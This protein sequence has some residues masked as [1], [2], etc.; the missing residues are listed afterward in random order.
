MIPLSGMSNRQLG[1]LIRNAATT[2]HE[3]QNGFWKFDFGGSLVFV[4]TDESHNRMR[5]MTPIVEVD[6]ISTD[7]LHLLLSAN[8]D[9][10]LDAR[11]CVNDNALWS[12]FLHPLRELD[13]RQFLDALKQVVT[14][15]NN[16]GTT[17]TSS[18]LVFGG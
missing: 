3:D 13:K 5:I 15:S 12:A 14:L 1:I 17:Y 9:R 10:A 6:T 4:I 11:Y 18:D 2:I 8:F 7:T 16:Y